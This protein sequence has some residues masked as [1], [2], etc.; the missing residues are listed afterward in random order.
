MR[1]GE[2]GYH[3][4]KTLREG[5]RSAILALL[6]I[7]VLQV[8]TPAAEKTT[9]FAAASLTSVL[10][11]LSAEGKEQGLE[12]RAVFASSS[13]LARQIEYGAPADIFISAN[14]GWMDYLEGLG[15]LEPETRRDL[16]ANALVIVAHA[17]DSFA[18]RVESNFDFA[19][20]FDGR[21]AVGDPTHVPV[22]I[23]ARQALTALG[24]WLGL[25]DRLAPAKD[26]L[27]ALSY[28]DLGEC[29]AGIVYA[30]DAALAENVKVAATFSAETH[31]P[32]VYPMAVVKGRDS[33]GARRMVTFLSSERAKEI[34]R[35][36]GF[37]TLVAGEKSGK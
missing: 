29:Q 2:T 33:D 23:Y 4:L 24:W 3:T 12:W 13:T 15:H 6:I 35:D 7:A 28:V 20:A 26:A 10:G 27:A 1:N 8:D 37:R 21:L 32:I 19:G 17:A 11:A 18:M 14:P 9:V 16:V 25:A 31:D 22:G 30:T 36:H 5:K 34:F